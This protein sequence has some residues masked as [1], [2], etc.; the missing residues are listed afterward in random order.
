MPGGPAPL[1]AARVTSSLVT[2]PSGPVPWM[3]DRSTPSFAARLR[4][5]GETL[6]RR[7][8][9]ASVPTRR[10]G[11]RLDRWVRRRRVVILGLRRFRLRRDFAFVADVGDRCSDPHLSKK[12]DGVLQQEAGTRRLDFHGDLVAFHH[13]NQVA[14]PYRASDRHQP[15]HDFAVFGCV[16]EIRHPHPQHHP[17]TPVCSL[18]EHVTSMARKPRGLR[19]DCWA[20]RLRTILCLAYHRLMSTESKKRKLAGW[21]SEMKDDQRPGLSGKAALITGGASGIGRAIAERF[22]AEGA[23][24]AVVDQD[25]VAANDAARQIPR[26]IACRADVTKRTSIEAATSTTLAQLGRL[27]ILVVSA[28]ISK[29]ARIL[30]M[31]DEDWESVIAVNLTGAFL[32]VQS[33]A[34][35]LVKQGWGRIIII[36]STCAQ[37]AAS[38]RANYNASKGGV[39][40]LMQSAACEL[41]PYGVTVNA[42]SPGPIDTPLSRRTHTAALRQAILCATPIKRYGLVEEIAAAAV[43]LASGEAAYVTG[44]ELT[45]DGGASA[46]LYIEDGPDT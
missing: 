9:R 6:R 35:H 36:A 33:A 45:V 8:G 25:A 44:H 31:S 43:Y 16:P 17:E 22:S 15:F 12:I 28:G 5:T 7:D 10:R 26:A 11:G 20:C 21:H 42:I 32:A 3:L 19:T 40:S 2:M 1:P 41:A 24:V 4:A 30:E 23:S 29:P 38:R 14:R 34:R 13:G 18:R 39:I 46:A 27:D 37:R